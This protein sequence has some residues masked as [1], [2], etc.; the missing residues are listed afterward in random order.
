MKPHNL[1][2]C[3]DYLRQSLMCYADTSLEIRVVNESGVKETP[4]WDVKR[5]R[6]FD[7]ILRWAQEW[8]A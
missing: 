6:D 8:R 7:A 1:R 5:C 2:H 3:I 4:D